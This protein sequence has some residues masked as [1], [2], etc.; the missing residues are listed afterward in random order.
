M[1]QEAEMELNQLEWW[2]SQVG[3]LSLKPVGL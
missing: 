1:A 2:F 3:T